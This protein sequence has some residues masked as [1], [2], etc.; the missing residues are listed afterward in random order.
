M[1]SINMDDV[2]KVLDS[3][4][5]HLAALAAVIVLGIAIMVAVRKLP[6]A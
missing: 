1:L 3:I 6:K 2:I 4:K 5:Y